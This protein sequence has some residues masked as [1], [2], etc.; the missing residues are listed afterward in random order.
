M[1]DEVKDDTP[2]PQTEDLS[3]TSFDEQATQEA[4]DLNNNEDSDRKEDEIVKELTKPDKVAQPDSE[5]EKEVPETKEEKIKE[6]TA[7]IKQAIKEAVQDDAPQETVEDL[8]KQLQFYQTLFGDPGSLP[9]QEQQPSP[10]QQPVQQ[11]Q[12]QPNI[13]DNVQVTQD[14]LLGL[15]SGEPERAVPV[16]K[17]FVATAIV[18]AQHNIVQQQQIQERQT[19]YISGVQEAFYQKYDGLVEEQYRPLVKFAGDQVHQEYLSRGIT[20]YP[21]EL[22]DDIGKRAMQLKEKLIAQANGNET[23][24]QP[25]KVIRQGEVGGTK[26]TPP[27]KVNLSDQQ[28]DMFDL[29]EEQ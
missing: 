14:E 18:L 8:K 27:P 6:A 21:H 15:L 24:Q 9:K 1:A 4:L 26:T 28:K 2:A 25:R 19:R 17:K 20:K 7:D 16:I 10:Q 22:I 23:T 3:K 12:Q 11:Q 29:L 5:P 13:L